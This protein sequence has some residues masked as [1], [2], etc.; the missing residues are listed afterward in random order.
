[1]VEIKCT[2][3]ILKQKPPKPPSVN[4]AM[5]ARSNMAVWRPRW[6]SNLALCTARYSAAR[7]ASPC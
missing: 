4:P 5:A 1:M 2:K 6:R 7:G 3:D